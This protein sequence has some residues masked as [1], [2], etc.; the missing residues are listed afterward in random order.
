MIVLGRGAKRVK[1]FRL[2]DVTIHCIEKLQERENSGRPSRYVPFS[3]A[4]V[5]ADAVK[6][7]FNSVFS[8]ERNTSPDAGE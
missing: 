6:H 3:E 4:D 2:D 8:S 7:Y 5:V 1:S